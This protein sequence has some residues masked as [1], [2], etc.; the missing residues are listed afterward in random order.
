MIGLLQQVVSKRHILLPAG[1]VDRRLLGL[2]AK[3]KVREEPMLRQVDSIGQL[4]HNLRG[5]LTQVLFAT[6][7]IGKQNPKKK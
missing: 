7:L 6:R 4:P 1:F 5:Y 3:I 2:A